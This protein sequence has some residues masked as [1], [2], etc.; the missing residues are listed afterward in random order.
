MKSTI[1]VIDHTQECI[2]A[3]N[4]A[5]ER[6]LEAIGMQAESHAKNNLTASGHIDTGLLRNSIAHAVSGEIPTANG[7]SSYQADRALSKYDNFNTNVK[8]DD[9][10]NPIAKSGQYDMPV[11]DAAPVEKAVY[12]GSNVHYAPY[13]EWGTDRI[14]P[15]HFIK[16]AITEHSTEYAEIAKKFLT[17][18]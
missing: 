14:A 18:G 6:A 5:I 4:E 3:K 10:G 1:E 11:P 7:Q 16:N 15:T 9:K 13:I 17:G 12:I 8:Y 2:D